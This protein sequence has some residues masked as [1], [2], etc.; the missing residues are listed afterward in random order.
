MGY[1]TQYELDFVG[2]IEPND[3][4]EIQVY[5]RSDDTMQ[6]AIVDEQECKWYDHE[7]DM[8]QMSKRFPYV[9]FMLRGQGE[10]SGDLW[11]KYFKDGKRQIAEARITYDEFDSNKLI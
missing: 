10:E 2:N 9:V 6:Y 3:Y 7:K 11:V 4:E 8:I 5:I 1:Y